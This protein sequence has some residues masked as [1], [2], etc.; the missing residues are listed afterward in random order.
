[1]SSKFQQ[2]K[3]NDQSI[4]L[5]FKFFKLVSKHATFHAELNHNEKNAIVQKSLG[6]INQ[7]FYAFTNFSD[8][9]LFSVVS[10]FFLTKLFDIFLKSCALSIKCCM[11]KYLFKFFI[12]IVCTF[13]NSKAKLGING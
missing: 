8:I 2:T 4:K 5:V 12:K 6:G 1:L 7:A 10:N 9:R 11:L 3:N 13:G